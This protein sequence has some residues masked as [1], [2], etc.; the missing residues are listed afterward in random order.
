M[1]EGSMLAWSQPLQLLHQQRQ[2]PEQRCNLAG[3]VPRPRK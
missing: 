1:E 3:I 2:Q